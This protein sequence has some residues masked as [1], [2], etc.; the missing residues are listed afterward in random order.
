MAGSG[1]TALGAPEILSLVPKPAL[2]KTVQA[3]IAAVAL[4]L[5]LAAGDVTV[6]AGSDI[7]T[8]WPAGDALGGVCPDSCTWTVI[9]APT[10][11]VVTFADDADPQ[12]TVTT[13]THGTFVLRLTDASMNSDDM[14]LTVEPQTPVPY[15]PA[16]DMAQLQA[17]ID[18][19]AQ[20]Y[21]VDGTYP[22]LGAD[23]VPDLPT[24]PTVTAATD[25][26]EV[27]SLAE[28]EAACNATDQ[29]IR[30]TTDI[31]GS[32]QWAAKAALA[33]AGE[34]WFFSVDVFT[35][36]ATALLEPTAAAIISDPDYG[37]LTESNPMPSTTSSLPTASSQATPPPGRKRFR[38]IASRYRSGK[39]TAPGSRSSAAVRVIVEIVW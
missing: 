11:G 12:T 1:I 23:V 32:A 2:F 15:Y 4:A 35:E 10:H 18:D 29:Y 7:A 21:G 17:D 37:S 28:L 16:A 36:N 6:N 8:T 5:P 26:V 13:N 25:L 19:A 38:D 24:L 30:F 27:A 39:G 33:S 9:T 22:T 14:T 20:L 3:G 31:A 34:S